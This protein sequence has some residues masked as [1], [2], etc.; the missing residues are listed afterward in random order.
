MASPMTPHAPTAGGLLDLLD[1]AGPDPPTLTGEVL[2][3][4]VEFELEASP[5]ALVLDAWGLRLGR[6]LLADAPRLRG[7]GVDDFAAADFLA[8][9]Y[10][11]DPELAEACVAPARRAFLAG[12]FATP[13]YRDLHADTALCEPA[14]AVAAVAFAEGYA[15][16]RDRAAEPRPDG[17][18]DDDEVAVIAAASRA[19]K[20]AAAEVGGMAD[21][22]EALGMGPGAA[23][24]GDPRAVAALYMLFR[25]DPAL[26]RVCDLAGRLRRVARSTRTV[27]ADDGV[28]EV[29]GVT[30]GGDVGRLLPAELAR[31]ASGVPELEL[32]ALRR[33][34][35]R[36]AWCREYAGTIP[37]GR[38]P[39]VVVVDESGSMDGPRVEAAKALALVVAAAARRERRWVGLVAYSGD[40]GERLLPLPP[41]RWDGVALAAWVTAF[42]GGGSALDVPLRELPGY[43]KDLGAPVGT[44]DVLVVTDAACRVPAAVAVAFNLWRRSAPAR[45]VALVVGPDAGGLAGVCDECHLVR[46][47]DAAAPA[48]ARV[49]AR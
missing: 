47:L 13:A 42:L 29:T 37:A 31:L 35:E 3:V 14:A 25:A 38:G 12:L 5:T 36:E 39:V 21:C 46:G 40:T 33:V 43:L 45:V 2:L 9:A 48:V 1:L 15:Q 18:A 49:L 30:T 6:E 23:G 22:A 24:A 8:A 28:D 20:A 44:T 17:G 16:L 26:K 34:A 7:L 10:L 19:A 27:R 32:D 41:G 4:P 11:P